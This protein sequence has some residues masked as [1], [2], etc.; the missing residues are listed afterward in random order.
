MGAAKHP[1]RPPVGL[2]PLRRQLADKLA[3]G[4]RRRTNARSALADRLDKI[5]RGA[6]CAF[7]IEFMRVWVAEI[8]SKPVADEPGHDPAIV[9][10][11]SAAGLAQRHRDVVH[12][13]RIALFGNRCESIHAARQ[14]S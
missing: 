2:D 8:G 13:P 6:D 7:G 5:E 1:H 9:F 3:R 4:E 12:F 10:D 14:H 11:N